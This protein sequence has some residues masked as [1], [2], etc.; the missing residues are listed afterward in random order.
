MTAICLRIASIATHDLEIVKKQISDANLL[1]DVIELRLDYWGKINLASLKQLKDLISLP[2]IFTLRQKSQGGFCEMPENERLNFI[3]ELAYLQPEYIDVEY[4]VSKDWLSNFHKNFPD[5]KLIGSYHNF[6]ETPQ[7]LGNIIQ[8]LS[9]P[10]FFA[11]KMVTYANNICD[12]LRLLIFLKNHSGKNQLIAFAMGEYGQISRILAPI[13]GGAATYGCIDQTSAT[14]PGQMTLQ[15][16]NQVYRFQQLNV[17]THIYSLLG[18]PISQSPGHLFHN[19]YFAKLKENAVYVKCRIASEN[20]P[21]AIRLM[22]ELPFYGMS[23]TIPHKETII[24]LLDELQDEAAAIKIANTIKRV[25]DLFIGYNTD[26]PG[27]A[28]VLE[29]NAAPLQNRQCLILGAGGSAKALAYMLL[30]KQVNV[31][32]CN[33][34]LERAKIFV[35]QFGG[36]AVDLTALFKVNIFPYDLIINTLPAPAYLEQCSNWKIPEKK[37][38]I[39][40][41]IVLKPLQTAFLKMAQTAGWQT[42]AGDALFHA[43]AINQLK[44]WFVGQV[45]F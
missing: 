15:E 4:D 35:D 1:A 16:L 38:G 40:M 44:I 9:Q 14:A 20:L 26:I 19:Q 5:I 17:D 43:Q 28:A 42:I 27:A 33:R 24:P 45:K 18:D 31:T 3:Y 2:V 6:A 13:F 21:E 34:T 41:D 25:D 37:N 30:K 22:R 7:D 29:K 39:A 36:Q 11:L 12:T 8:L 32:I 23:I 10:E